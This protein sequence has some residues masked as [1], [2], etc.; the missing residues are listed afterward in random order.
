MREAAFVKSLNQ[1]PDELVLPILKGE[2]SI[3]GGNFPGSY[4]FFIFDDDHGGVERDG[5][6]D[7]PGDAIKA[8]AH[9][10]LSAV[11]GFDD[12]MFFAVRNG[13]GVFQ[14]E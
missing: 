10:V 14:I 13:F 12:E 3:A 6:T 2:G 7:V 4:S 9:P 11:A 1:G 5:G 8:V